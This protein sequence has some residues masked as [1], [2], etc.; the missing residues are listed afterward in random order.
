MD[1]DLLNKLVEKTLTSTDHDVG[2]VP[3]KD[4]QQKLVPLKSSVELQLLPIWD[5]PTND[6][7]GPTYKKYI[8]K[9]SLYKTIYVR[10]VLAEKINQVTQFIPDHWQLIIRAGHR[11][12]DV[13][14]SLLDQVAEK[15]LIDNPEATN[16]Q[17]LSHARIYISD[18]EQKLPPHTC[19]AAIDVDAKDRTSQ[20]LIDF[21][22]GVNTQEAISFWNTNALT[23]AQLK[24][25]I[26]LLKAMI[27][28]GFAP[29]PNEWWH[30]SYG[31]QY[32]A[33]FYEQPESL[34]GLIEATKQD[35]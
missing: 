20:E 17:A 8:A 29:H 14:K 11:P 5:Y 4:I 3:C 15:Y 1:N 28:S 18:P 10:Q 32:W 7:E 9:N 22:C 27:Q 31:D 13:Q 12:F 19:G 30:F 26:S 34:F 25:R 6:P 23:Q 21:G 33:D 35:N 2:N 16:E 24:N